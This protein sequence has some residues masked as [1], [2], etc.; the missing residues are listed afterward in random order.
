M[1]FVLSQYH[2]RNYLIAKSMLF[3]NDNRGMAMKQ[4]IIYI[5]ALILDLACIPVVV[6]QV[7][8]VNTTGWSFTGYVGAK[9]LLL[10]IPF[11]FIAGVLIKSLVGAFTED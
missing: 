6:D 9:T 11:A 4:V 2:T 3:V 8:D 5:V 10:L 7:Q 1:L